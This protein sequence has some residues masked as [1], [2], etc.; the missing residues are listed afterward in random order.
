MRGTPG[1]SVQ[2][3][4]G[5]A[6]MGAAT[7][8]FNLEKIGEAL[9]VGMSPVTVR[10]INNLSVNWVPMNNPMRRTAADGIAAILEG[11]ADGKM[12]ATVLD[13]PG[14]GT[15]TRSLGDDLVRFLRPWLAPGDG[16]GSKINFNPDGK[17]GCMGDKMKQRPPAIGLAHELC[18]AWR[19]AVGQRLFDDAM[20]CNLDDDEVM[21]CGFPPY[22]FE[23][24][25]ENLFRIELGGNLPLRVNYR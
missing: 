1:I 10:T 21:T 20:S 25:S 7:A 13:P 15:G 2:V 5:R 11:V 8:G 19:N 18:H 22:Q 16:S 12:P 17:L 14:P 9:A 3:E 24:Y 6:L 4:L 23:K